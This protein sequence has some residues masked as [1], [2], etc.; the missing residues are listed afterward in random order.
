MHC[1]VINHTPAGYALRQTDAHPPAAAH[2]RAA[3]RCASRAAPGRRSPSSAGS[4][5]RCAAAGSSS[6]AKSCATTPK[7][8]PRRSKAR[9]TASACPVVVLPPDAGKS[10]ADDTLPQII[11]AAGAFGVDQGVA[12]TRAGE[13][14]FAVLTKLVEQ[15]PGFEIYDYAAV[16]LIAAL[17]CTAAARVPDRRPLAAA[18]GRAR[19]GARA[20]RSALGALARAAAARRLLARAEGAAARVALV[21][22][23]A[24]Q[25]PG[26]AGREPAAAALRRRGHRARADRTR[27]ACAMSPPW[28]RRSR[29]PRWPRYCCRSARKGSVGCDRPRRHA[30]LTPRRRQSSR[31]GDSQVAAW[32]CRPLGNGNTMRSATPSSSRTSRAP[33]SREPR[34]DLLHQHLGR[35]RAGRDADGRPFRRPT[36]ARSWSA[37]S[38]M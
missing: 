2:R 26:A 19:R 29:S 20:L 36:R 1:Q 37:R 17:R 33:S 35:R 28:P 6:A 22:A 13:T 25:A 12:L 10:G 31:R 3:W 38:I 14:G 23:R 16:S 32:P 18:G 9:R 27:P 4:A 7:P 24:R 11:V 30:R 5:T 21:S 15:G 8:R 34:E